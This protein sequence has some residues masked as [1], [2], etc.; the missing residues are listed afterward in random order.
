MLSV[1][2]KVTK[3]TFQLFG[4]SLHPE[5]FE[6]Y[7]QR[8]IERDRYRLRYQI[9]NVGHVISCDFDGLVLSEVAAALYQ[10]LP[11]QRRLMS[12]DIAHQ[13]TDTLEYCD[14]IRY[15]CEFQQELVDNKCFLACQQIL[16]KQTECE[17]LFYQ[18]DSSGR[19]PLGAVSYVNIETRQRAFRIRAFHTFPDTCCMVKSS[20]WYDLLS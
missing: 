19:I 14:R 5:L 1:R 2:P 13:R 16:T 10:P 4:R 15:R 12:H 9:T 6:V 20:S 8:T 3:L 7:A 17:G 11:Q 18:F